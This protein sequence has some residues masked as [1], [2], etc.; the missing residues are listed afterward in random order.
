MKK[1]H[2][3]NSYE[4]NKVPPS[5]IDSAKEQFG[6]PFQNESIEDVKSFLAILGILLTLGPTLA[7]ELAAS[8]Q[9]PHFGHHLDRESADSVFI[10]SAITPLVVVVIVP[11]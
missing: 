7:V 4:D 3:Q 5:R 2:L 11:V 9:L 6:G 1:R 10:I 8:E